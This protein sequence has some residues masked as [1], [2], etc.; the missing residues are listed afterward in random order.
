MDNRFSFRKFG[1][2][3]LLIVIISVIGSVLYAIGSVGGYYNDFSVLLPLLVL[4]GAAAHI[5]AMLLGD[6]FGAETR[7]RY[8]Q[9]LGTG[10]FMTAAMLLLR[11]R[12][13]SFAIL[14]GSDLEASNADAYA[15]V[16]PSLAAIIAFAAAAVCGILSAFSLPQNRK[17]A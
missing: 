2:P 3:L 6:R 9:V 8:L 1:I 10:I 7:W 5:A 13:F 16:Y 17:S 12:A 4:F 14:L 15:Q 11:E